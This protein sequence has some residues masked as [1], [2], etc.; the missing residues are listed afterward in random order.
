MKVQR[1]IRGIFSRGFRKKK[2]ISSFIKIGPMGAA[3]FHADRQTET[4][5]TK[6]IVAFKNSAKSPKNVVV[7]G[8]K[9]KCELDRTYRC[10]LCHF[11]VV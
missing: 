6:L 2:V 8:S 10:G 11:A 7:E 1:R 9:D 5:M 3:L 4:E